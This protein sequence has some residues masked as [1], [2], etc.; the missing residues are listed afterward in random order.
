MDYFR[1]SHETRAC[2]QSLEGDLLL[3]V[4]I[5]AGSHNERDVDAVRLCLGSGRRVLIEAVPRDVV[6]GDLNTE[7]F[8]LDAECEAESDPRNG[9]SEEWKAV[10]I[11]GLGRVTSVEGR[12]RRDSFTR[13]DTGGELFVARYEHGVL[14]RLERGGLIVDCA[15]AMPMTVNVEHWTESRQVKES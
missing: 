3:R 15:D 4:E 7:I 10:P 8:V 1:C 9:T 2:L 12:E 5:P 14:V 13:A 11:L 6:V